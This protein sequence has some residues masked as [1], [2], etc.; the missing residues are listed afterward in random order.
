[1]QIPFHL[2]QHLV[3]FSS[4]FCICSVLVSNEAY[5]LLKHHAAHDSLHIIWTC[6][7]FCAPQ[8]KTTTT[9]ETF[10][11]TCLKHPLWVSKLDRDITS[12]QE[13][14]R[15]VVSFLGGKSMDWNNQFLAQKIREGEKMLRSRLWILVQKT[16]ARVKLTGLPI[17]QNCTHWL[18]SQGVT[19]E[20]KTTKTYVAV[21]S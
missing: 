11:L 7:D 16:A 20:R 2:K 10:L 3:W 19:A 6:L 21:I 4:N 17:A 5:W 18:K 1:M 15:L 12:L 8:C 13:I 9:M 14:D